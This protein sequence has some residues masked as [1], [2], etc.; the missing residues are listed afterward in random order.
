MQ[1][2]FRAPFCPTAKQPPSE[3]NFLGVSRSCP[4]DLSQKAFYVSKHCLG[5]PKFFTSKR[6][7]NW[8]IHCEV[9]CKQFASY[10]VHV[11]QVSEW[12]KLGPRER[13]EENSGSHEYSEKWVLVLGSQIL[14]KICRMQRTIQKR[15]ETANFL[16]RLINRH[17][18]KRTPLRQGS[19]HFGWDLWSRKKEGVCLC[20]V[21]L[22]NYYGCKITIYAS[23]TS[24]EGI[25]SNP[26]NVLSRTNA[27]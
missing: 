13:Y 7:Q 5:L 3:W 8:S 18:R 14:L 15:R 16:F 24:W 9:K 12:G 19:I 22:K 17:T 2:S 26:C 6:T 10:F 20:S 4:A 25:E 11:A 1:T 21:Q 27:T 23:V